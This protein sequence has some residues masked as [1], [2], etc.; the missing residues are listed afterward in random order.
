MEI[1]FNCRHYLGE[2]PC[3]YKCLCDECRY[4]SPQG[5]R[6]L[7]LKLGAIG[8]A[9]RTTPILHALEREY[10][11][12]HV[13]W[14]TDRPSFPILDKNPYIDKL[15]VAET[16]DIMAVLSQ[17]FDIL[18]N[19]DKAPI[20]ISLAMQ[21]HSRIRRGFGM[22]Q[23]G[24]LEILND[25]SMYS[26]MLGL[27]DDLKF[28]RNTKSYQEIIYEM[29]ELPYRRDPYIYNLQQD[30]LRC[31]RELISSIKL[32]ASGPQIGFNTGCGDIFATKKWPDDHFIQLAMKLI[33][34]LDA[35]IYLL[36]GQKEEEANR[37]IC[38]ALNGKAVSLGVNP[39]GVFAGILK[40]MDAVVT[41]DTMAMHLALAVKTPIIAL[42][43]PTC[44]QEIDFFDSGYALE[45]D[46]QCAPCYRSTC[47]N[48]VFCM[49]SI[50]PPEVTKWVIRLLKEHRSEN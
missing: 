33:E 48:E 3:K 40:S 45:A 47:S 26:L 43:G 15:L 37:Q 28:H 35:R 1:K 21:V 12:R 6:I 16:S 25:A 22:S 11:L 20:T 30:D 8:D 14:M 5:V 46:C 27:D 42:F 44:S 29:A 13:S 4:Y 34:K 10:P 18:L 32:E 2:K 49:S 36:G 31:A 23:W 50:E 7:I 39:L 9:L 38:E 41:S 17:K 24:T 19:F